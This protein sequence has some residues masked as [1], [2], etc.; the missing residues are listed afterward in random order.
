MSK[1]QLRVLDLGWNHLGKGLK[2]D[3]PPPARRRGQPQLELSKALGL[4]LEQNKT[5]VH[6]D[7]CSNKFRLEECQDISQG[8]ISNNSIFGMHFEGNFGYIDSE[9]FLVLDDAVKDISSEHLTRKIDSVKIHNN[10]KK[11]NN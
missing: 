1:F 11:F 10:F 6:L 5:L 8:M 4:F 9:G 2:V 3:G 7:L